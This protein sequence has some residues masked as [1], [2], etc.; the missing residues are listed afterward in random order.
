MLLLV[1][2]VRLVRLVL[3]LVLLHMYLLLRQHRRRTEN[4][5][6]RFPAQLREEDWVLWRLDG[7]K[8]DLKNFLGEFGYKRVSTIQIFSFPAPSESR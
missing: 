2:L 7:A 5:T 3:V 8:V 6:V 4:T 1:R